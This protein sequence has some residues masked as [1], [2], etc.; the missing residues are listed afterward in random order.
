MNKSFYFAWLF[1]LPAFCQCQVYKYRCFEYKLY[2]DDTKKD[3]KWDSSNILVVLNQTKLKVNTFG[4]SVQDIDLIRLDTIIGISKSVEILYQ[5][6]NEEG[7]KC[8]VHI[9]S[10]VPDFSHATDMIL[11]FSK[12]TVSMR[13]KEN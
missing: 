13:L 12:Y 6:I 4:K 7:E 10:T 3:S 11:N 1:L 8:M 2:F 9:F 5:G